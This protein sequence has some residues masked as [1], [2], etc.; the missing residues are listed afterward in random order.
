MTRATDPAFYAPLVAHPA[1][2]ERLL[3]LYVKEEMEGAIGLATILTTLPD[4]AAP[5]FVLTTTRHCCDEIRHAGHFAA[6]IAELGG[7]PAWSGPETSILDAMFADLY[8]LPQRVWIASAPR[9]GIGDVLTHL[10]I[11]WV[12][13]IRAVE[14]LRALVAAA[15]RSPTTLVARCEAILADEDFHIA[16]IERELRRWRE[17][18]RGEEVDRKLAAA[19]ASYDRAEVAYLRVL[20]GGGEPGE[21]QHG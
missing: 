3:R 2:L 5:H 9:L 18:G 12:L 20:E 6:V 21:A 7:R 8:H 17:R 14:R 10:T 11:S 13:E 15:R 16:Y 19:L 1:L 4:E